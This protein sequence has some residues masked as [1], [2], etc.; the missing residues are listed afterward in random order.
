MDRKERE[1][2]SWI[3][4]DY[5][6]VFSEL[7]PDEILFRGSMTACKKWAKKNHGVVGHVISENTEKK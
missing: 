2:M 5:W 3:S 1:E 7:D 6:A 4:V